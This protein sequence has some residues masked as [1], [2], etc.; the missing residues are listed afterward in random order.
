MRTNRV[1]AIVAFCTMTLAIAAGHAQ[2]KPAPAAAA[3]TQPQ[4]QGVL[5]QYCVTCH[6]AQVKAGSLELQ[7]KD[8]SRLETHPVVWESV[9]RK[10]RT[11]MMPPPSARRPERATLDGVAAWL[12][13]GLDRVA[14]RAPNPGSPSLHRMNRHE[15]AN[16]VRDLLDLEVDVTALLPSDSTVAGFDN[17]ADVLGTSPALAQ[18]YVSAAMKISR[19]AIGDLTAPPLPVTHSPPAGASQSAHVDG[20]P[21]GTQGG[22]VVRHIFPVDA[23]YQIQAGGGGR[24][25]ITIDG[26]P[27]PAGRG[28]IPI[29]AGP[30]TIRVANVAGF[31]T[32]RMDGIFSA[33][34]GRGRGMSVTITGPFR[35]SGPGDTP[36]R[37]RIFVCGSTALTASRPMTPDQE[38]ACARTIIQTL[39]RRAFRRHVPADDPS[40][41][42]LM[43]FYRDARSAGTFDDGVQH[44][45]ARVLV[46][47][48]FVFR[49]EHVPA[50]LADGAVYRLK[51][52][53]IATRLSFFL[54][55]SVPD[56]ALLDLAIAGRLSDRAVLERETR[57]MLADPKS[58]ALI[59]N[60]AAQWMHLR[61]LDNAQP[62][63]PD[64]DGSLRVS[65]AREM[66]LFF[67]SVLRE[68]RS[69]I[70][71]LDADY[72]FVD[73]RLARHYGIPGVTGSFFRRVP[74]AANHPRRGV[75]GKGSVLLVTSVANRTSPVERGQWVLENLLGSPAPNPPPGVETNLDQPVEDT[76]KPMTLR[77]RMD[78]HRR[79]P[80]CASCH[81]IMDP[82]GFSLEN[83]DLVGKWREQDGGSPIDATGVMVD[84]TRLDGPASLRRALLDRSNAFVSVASEKLLTYAVGRVMTPSDMPAVRAIVRNAARNDYRFS[85]LVVG[86]VD[87]QP[88]QMRTVD[89]PVP[90]AVEGPRAAAAR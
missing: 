89:R 61:E 55:S 6:N 51:D 28:R 2:Q 56:D 10:L 5:N 81:S 90:S 49:M 62:D 42:T 40:L 83:F 11:G 34:A 68:D 26:T 22:M 35:P 21:L 47:P 4:V 67:G 41:Q 44:A 39:A 50:N 29:P 16:A 32:A 71:L 17:I 7:D 64:F 76:G 8:L 77:Q 79:Q 85:S 15:Y 80:T 24:I 73:E 25:D 9:V 59:D 33:P 13:A 82:I 65:F 84:G 30:R 38:T 14:A 23:E 45:V 66:Q 37:R 54:W 57:R 53:E 48:Q 27:I 46:D 86:V 69:L 58:K 19:L 87:S 75:L 12:E 31:D 52:T 18:S 20:L 88:F 43:Q 60:F 36:S 70:D 74:L 1:I 78:L 3:S 63:S 72:T